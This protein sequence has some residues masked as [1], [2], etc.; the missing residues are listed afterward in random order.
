MIPKFRAGTADDIEEICDLVSDAVRYMEECGI[1]Q[2]DSLYPARE[3]FLEDIERSELTV[4]TVDGELAVIYTLNR[5]C[6][7]EYASAS[8]HSPDDDFCVIHRLCVKPKHQHKGIAKAALMNIEEQLK[9]QGV[10]SIRLDVFSQ[11][12]GA[13]ALYE[14]AG[15]K[16]TGFADWRMGRFY[17]MEKVI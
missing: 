3:D 7:E 17:I 4:G 14:H 9:A 10:N 6:D 11:N 5:R 8:W 15:Y 1:C 12:P 2:W 13:L 16:R